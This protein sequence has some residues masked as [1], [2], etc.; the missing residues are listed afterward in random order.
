MSGKYD[1]TLSLKMDVVAMHES[2]PT[3]SKLKTQLEVAV[4]M[5]NSIA[6]EDSDIHRSVRA[7]MYQHASRV[8]LAKIKEME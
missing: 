1:E 6:E 5:L 2:S 3:I 4:V 8:A 7:D